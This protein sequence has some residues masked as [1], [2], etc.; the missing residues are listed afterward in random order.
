MKALKIYS[1]KDI[2]GRRDE[3]WVKSSEHFAQIREMQTKMA[4]MFSADQIERS[5]KDRNTAESI[6]LLYEGALK[7]IVFSTGRVFRG[8][9]DLA[10]LEAL[11]QQIVADLLAFHEFKARQRKRKA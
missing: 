11:T 1:A 7:K 6:V 10:L 5:V 9:Q 4:L 3:G 2:A 8:P